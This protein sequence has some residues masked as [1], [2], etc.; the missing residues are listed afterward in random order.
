MIT[1]YRN[2][3]I[4]EMLEYLES[5]Y[6]KAELWLDYAEPGT[7]EEA[8]G[9]SRLVEIEYQIEMCIRESKNQSN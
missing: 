5:E 1:I 7:E 4:Q 3:N 8:K 2:A 9:L 6:N